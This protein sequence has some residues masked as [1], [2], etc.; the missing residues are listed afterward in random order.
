M[1]QAV[2][3]GYRLSPQQKHLWSQR[4]PEAGRSFRAY[5]IAIIEGGLEK[6]IL[7]ETVEKVIARHEVLRT[8]FHLAAGKR[9]P[10]QVIGGV[11]LLWT[12]RPV[13]EGAD[14]ADQESIARSLIKEAE[15]PEVDLERGPLF[16][17]SISTL[18]PDRHALLVCA[19]AFCTDTVGL[20]NLIKE[21]AICYQ[22][23]LTGEELR[24]EPIQYADL[25]EWLN[26]LQEGEETETGREYWR[27]Q[28]M[29][30]ASGM[31]LPFE[32]ALNENA[33]FEP[34]VVS[35]KI[36]AGLVGRLRQV[37]TANDASLSAL[38][39]AC[40]QVLLWRLGG[41][42][43]LVVGARDEGR[44]YE[45]LDEA[46]G[47]FAK[48]LPLRSYL[49]PDL[50]FNA[51]LQ[52]VRDSISEIHEWQ[53]YFNW[54]SIASK[55]DAGPLGP[56]HFSFCY[57][58][59]AAPEPYQAGDIRFSI[60]RLEAC[61]DRYKVRLSCAEAGDGLLA[62][63]H[64][65]SSLF[66]RSGIERSASQFHK[67]LESAA[68]HP[69]SAITRLEVLGDR[70]R[71]HILFELNDTRADYISDAAFH[72]LFERQAEGAPDAIAVVCGDQQLS[73][74]ELDERANRLAR[75]L[76]AL[77]VNPGTLVGICLER[78]VTVAVAVLGVLKAEAAYVPLDPT[79]P[80]DRLG[81]MLNDANVPLLLTER[82]MARE[83]PD[84]DARVV[85]LDVEWDDISK[86]SPARPAYDSHLAGPAYVIY[87]SGSTGEPR[88]VMV[89]HANLCQYV[90]AMGK[91]LEMKKGDR[92]LHT[93]SISFSSSVRQ[94]AVPLANGAAVVI[95]TTEQRLDPVALFDLVK[96]QG[97][98]IINLVPSHW[99]N[100]MQALKHLDPRS[101]ALLLDNDLRLA[102]SAS[103]P[104]T[105]DVPQI[106][107]SEFG[108]RADFINML[109]QTET[110]GI[111]AT[112]PVRRRRT[113]RTKIVPVGRPIANTQIYLLN[114]HMDPVPIGATGELH[115]GG[116]DVGRGYLNRPELTAERF[117]PDPFGERPG[118]R[119]YKA[120]DLARYL[121]DGNIEFLGRNDQ[122]VKIRGFR[123]ELSE[124]EAALSSHQAIDEAVVMAVGD[125]A[126]KR[127]AAFVVP[128]QSPAP[129]RD[130]LQSYLKERLPAYMI[131]SA[132]TILDSLPLTPN[133]KLDRRALLE[134]QQ[135]SAVRDTPFV[136]PR[137]PVEERLADIWSRVLRVDQVGIHDDF[138]KLGGHSL[139]AT[140]LVSR[141]R[142]AFEI[143]LP[144][145]TLFESPT[146]A[147]L[148]DTIEKH[149]IKQVD[150]KQLF[151]MMQSIEGMSDEEVHALLSSEGNQIA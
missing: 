144:V 31:A 19:S 87:T 92:F 3:E 150:A 22:A 106:W 128:K 124:I 49:W 135:E 100:C 132:I 127:L 66:S 136:A 7:R 126:D 72:G 93:A 113:S 120:G 23:A 39:L 55:T 40:W 69:E 29:A 147:E 52:K 108:C 99:R 62:D 131:P 8:T 141:V 96:R 14:A 107:R 21:I 11:S 90:Q 110:C 81:F 57:D 54:D 36:D 85:M 44:S 91:S 70:E 63:F 18:A 138:F 33:P 12:E 94:I 25:S 34:D 73:Y 26:E 89:T 119:L 95:A 149:L 59:E 101:R 125:A 111:V 56:R 129:S 61:I 83:I 20:K 50:S 15:R 53:E 76:R 37:A 140:V 48:Y 78:S 32:N 134:Y 79:Y 121:D 145:V 58:Y 148:A 4:Q 46:I 35:L 112:Y 82:N 97:V 43:E 143:E 67:L 151:E 68:K 45:G 2:V 47:L 122:Q 88:G 137:T 60:I 103:E 116:E 118:A 80:T 130:G 38:M 65:D 1:Q 13:G 139:L 123:V 64:F 24:D 84:N 142:D 30:A 133:G 6:P 146:V 102:L 105:S 114:E 75:Y 41:Q 98:T 17:F 117:T 10:V 109:G 104:L 74:G 16:H 27:G 71:R 28:D 5:C 115:I 86:Q 51:L 77:G 42:A 9:F